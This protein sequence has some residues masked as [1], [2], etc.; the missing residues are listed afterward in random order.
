MFDF[1][2]TIV[3]TSEA[4]YSVYKQSFEKITGLQFEKQIWDL[5]FGQGIIYICKEH[6]NLK[7]DII[8]HIYN[9]KFKE[10]PENYF[11]KI[12]ILDFA[13]KYYQKERSLNII[14]TSTTKDVVLKILKNKGIDKYFHSIYDRND[15]TQPKP[16][17]KIYV[18]AASK[19]LGMEQFNIF[20][21]SQMGLLA[22]MAFKG[23]IPKTKVYK[24]EGNNGYQVA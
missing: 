15:T 21:D 17:P 12:T 19:Y 10:Y 9:A 14:C 4:L 5:Q 2:G 1:D 18:N 6:Y 16:S 7:D 24:I 23:M 20:E 11:D 13:K 8:E 22:A 3:D